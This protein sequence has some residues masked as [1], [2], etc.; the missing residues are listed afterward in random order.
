MKGCLEEVPLTW[1]LRVKKSQKLG[2]IEIGE[3]HLMM[4]GK[5]S[6]TTDA[7]LHDKPLI[8]MFFGKVGLEI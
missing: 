7:N 5:L 6:L 3:E 8:D 1:I 2:K 4:R